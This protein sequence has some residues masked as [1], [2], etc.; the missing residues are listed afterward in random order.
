MNFFM[1]F[2][3]KK[4]VF[5]AEIIKIKRGEKREILSISRNFENFPVFRQNQIE[6]F[7]DSFALINEIENLSQ[8]TL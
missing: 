4:I 7:L 1:T 3:R 2:Q 8:E 5:K 6:M